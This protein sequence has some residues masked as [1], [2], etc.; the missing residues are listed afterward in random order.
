MAYPTI[1]PSDIA[2]F[3]LDTQSGIVAEWHGADRPLFKIVVYHL[4]R[5]IPWLSRLVLYYTILNHYK[6][7]NFAS[8]L[9]V[10][11]PFSPSDPLDYPR[12]AGVIRTVVIIYSVSIVPSSS[13]SEFCSLSKFPYSLCAFSALLVIVPP[14]ITAVELWTATPCR[15]QPPVG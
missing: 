14:C 1:L 6:T 8:S 11:L 15:N 7:I 13:W 2:F 5:L 4:R 12:S 10:M 9:I 3:F